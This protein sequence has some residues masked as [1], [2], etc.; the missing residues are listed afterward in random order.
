MN[1]QL[2]NDKEPRGLWIGGNSLGDMPRKVFFRPAWSHRGRHDFPRGD[3]EVG[4]QTLRPVAQI[5]ILRTLDH[6]WLHGQGGG[7]P[8]Q[9]LYPGFLI[10]TDDMPPLLGD[11]WRVLIDLAHRSH[12]GGKRN[13][14]IRLGVEPIFHPMWL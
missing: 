9:R 11:G 4:D 12:L 1:V 13:G 10:R 14:V 7:R 5:F 2:I 6:A 8:L 3:V